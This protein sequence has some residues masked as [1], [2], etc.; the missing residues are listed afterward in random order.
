MQGGRDVDI[1]APPTHHYHYYTTNTPLFYHYY[2]TNTPLL[3]HYQTS[4]GEGEAKHLVTWSAP[5]GLTYSLTRYATPGGSARPPQGPPQL[6]AGCH[7]RSMLLRTLFS[8]PSSP[9]VDWVGTF[10]WVGYVSF[11]FSTAGLVYWGGLWAPGPAG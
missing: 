6:A 1:S 7:L 3:H 10:P 9:P 4:F 8:G 2:T 11:C 5:V